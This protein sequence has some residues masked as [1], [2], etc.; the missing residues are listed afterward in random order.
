[1]QIPIIHITHDLLEVL[2]SA[3]SVLPLEQGK[4]AYDWLPPALREQLPGKQM[5]DCSIKSSEGEPE[6]ATGGIKIVWQR[7]FGYPGI[8]RT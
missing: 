8:C 7:L 3:D 5:H 6:K 2:Q 1:M 4:V